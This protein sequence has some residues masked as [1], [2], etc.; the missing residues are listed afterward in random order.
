MDPRVRRRLTDGW[1]ALEGGDYERAAE[2]AEALVDTTRRHPDAL[3]LLGAALVELGCHKAGLARL[4]EAGEQ[5]EDLA[6]SKC[7]EG[8]AHFERCRFA[9]ARRAF[10][11]AIE[12][13]PDFG[14]A[15][16][17]L[18]RCA[19]FA[20]RY[21]LADRLYLRAN[22]LDPNSCPLPVRMR[23]ANFEAAVREAI[24][25]VPDDL[26]KVLNHIPVIV[27]ELPD[28]AVLKSDTP[29]MRP[30]LLGLFVGSGL[31]EKSVFDLPGPECIMIFQRN[32][33]LFCETREELV[34]EIHV[35]L[36]HEV[37]HALGLEEEDLQERGL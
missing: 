15:Y 25:L 11:A 19:D 29:P 2:I 3:Q 32:L 13:E 36:A 37:G 20:K 31:R 24:D 27:E 30:D 34:Y 21:A 9:K 22:Q 16:F 28:P 35:T 6:L 23:R 18:G 8:N 26:R 17:G 1:R 7:Y 12:R 5:V 4:R 14:Y 33:E 10:Q